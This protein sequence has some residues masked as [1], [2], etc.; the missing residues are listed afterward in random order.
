MPLPDST[1]TGGRGTPRPERGSRELSRGRDRYAAAAEALLADNDDAAPDAEN[2]HEYVDMTWYCL[3]AV[4]AKELHKPHCKALTD[5]VKQLWRNMCMLKRHTEKVQR[6]EGLADAGSGPSTQMVP[7]CFA[8]VYSQ[9]H[10]SDVE[11]FFD[12]PDRPRK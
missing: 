7:R 10:A 5:L 11:S 1:P 6:M 9:G 3:S 12:V 2:E 4:E 8:N